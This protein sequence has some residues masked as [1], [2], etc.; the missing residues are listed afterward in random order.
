MQVV[1]KFYKKSP[2]WP[3][4]A[5][6][7]VLEKI[8]SSK[9]EICH[10]LDGSHSNLPELLVGTNDSKGSL[11]TK[12]FLELNFVVFDSQPTTEAGNFRKLLRFDR[13]SF[14]E[15]ALKA[16]QGKA[17]FAHTTEEVYS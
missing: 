8:G 2:K 9:Y 10:V 12:L 13:G 15:S 5:R 7:N 6:F 3:D 11:E 16:F 4:R 1:V 14:Q 17:F